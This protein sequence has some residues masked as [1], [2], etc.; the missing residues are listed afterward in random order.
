MKANLT[1]QLSLVQ[2]LISG[3]QKHLSTASSLSFGGQTTT[4][5]ALIALLTAWIA[6]VNVLA[7]ARAQTKNALAAERAQ[8]VAIEGVVKALIAYVE[9]TYTDAAVLADFGLAPRKPHAAHRGRQGTGRSAQ[10]GHA[11]GARDHGEAPEGGHPRDGDRTARGARGASA[12]QDLE[13]G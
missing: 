11:R 1:R 12:G 2:S 8:E 3:I 9:A 6:A 4:P 5:A 10:E 13:N 7:A